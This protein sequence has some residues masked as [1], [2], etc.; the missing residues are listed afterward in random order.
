MIGLTG[1]DDLLQPAEMNA[2]TL[3]T[4]YIDPS[5]AQPYYAK[6]CSTVMQNTMTSK[7]RHSVNL[8]KSE[9]LDLQELAKI[10]N[11]SMAWLGRQ[12]IIRLLEQHKQKEFQSP[13][14]LNQRIGS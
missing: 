7:E 2:N 1:C 10:N 9:S 14:A 4:K 11:V 6:R 13:L 5:P 12:A 3:I 8:D